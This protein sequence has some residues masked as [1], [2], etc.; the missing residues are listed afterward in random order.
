MKIVV[1]SFTA[2]YLPCKWEVI[3]EINY[4]NFHIPC[5][6]SIF[7]CINFQFRFLSIRPIWISVV[8]F[9]LY[10]NIFIQL[11]KEMNVKYF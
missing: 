1:T 3:L 7:K 4:I 5:L 9:I 10:F 8:H 11:H 2:Q 6:G